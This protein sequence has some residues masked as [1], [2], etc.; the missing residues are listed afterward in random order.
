MARNRMLSP[1]FWLDEE[2]SNVSPHARLLYMGLWGICDD[3]YATFPDKPN[4]IK[5]QVFPWE[6]VNTR[7][8]LDEL[9]TIGKILP[10]ESG[11]E[12]YWF[13]KNF[14]KYQRV[15]RPSKPKY[16]AYFDR[17][18]TTLD[19]HSTSTRPEVR[20]EKRREVKEVSSFD[21][22]IPQSV[23]DTIKKTLKKKYV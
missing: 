11:G 21:S 22:K 9:S 4:W 2:M 18:T 13:I 17:K 10:F 23:K 3:H 6:S 15:D 5:I 14:F 16:P 19:E 8:L 20:E 12:K 7:E 1:E